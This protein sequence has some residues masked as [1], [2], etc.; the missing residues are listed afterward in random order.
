MSTPRH[1]HA[2]WRKAILIPFWVVQSCALL[3]MIGILSL[4]LGVLASWDDD[5]LNDALDDQVNNINIGD[6]RKA[7]KMYVP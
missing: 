1:N 5:K 7:T 3:G 6:A 4:S 2:P